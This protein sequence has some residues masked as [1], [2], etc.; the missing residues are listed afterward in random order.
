MHRK[1]KL[2]PFYRCS[3]QACDPGLSRTCD[4]NIY[5]SGQCYLFPQNLK[6]PVLQGRPG[7]QGKELG[8]QWVNIPAS[9]WPYMGTSMGRP[10]SGT[11]YQIPLF[12]ASIEC[13]KGNVDLVF[14]FDGSGSLQQDEFQK[15]L[16]FMKD[17]M[18]KLSNS[19]YQASILARIPGYRC[20]LKA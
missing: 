18:K 3:L 15:I 5:L 9:G 7:Y 1:R 8:T 2:E 19:S 4:Q 11:L 10:T 17:V 14:L 16:A 13:L 6:G 12:L 20:F